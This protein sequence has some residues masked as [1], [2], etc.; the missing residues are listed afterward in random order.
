MDENVRVL[1]D[2]VAHAVR[3]GER[4]LSQLE[5][6]VETV[7]AK[8]QAA[9]AA[10]SDQGDQLIVD[11]SQ[12]TAEFES[13]VRGHLDAQ[14]ERLATF[15]IA[16][17]GR[18]GAGKSTLLSAFG[19]LDGGYVSPGD[20]D[21]T[22]DVTEI[23]WQ[24]C[25][26]WDT[27]GIN[28]WGR[29]Q[30]RAE[31]EETARQAVDI[32]DVVL[33]CF[34][35]QSQQASEFGKVA[36]WVQAYGK[37]TIAVLNVRNLRWRHPAKVSSQS[38]RRSLS[39]AVGEH[40]NNIRTELAKI[41]LG[42]TPV[43]AIQSRR[44]LFGRAKEPFNGPAVSNFNADREQFGAEYLA[45]W[46]NFSVLED[47]IAASIAEGGAELRQTSLREGLRGILDSRAAR[48]DSIR[49]EID[50]R[51]QFTG[52]RIDQFFDT[53]G[54]PEGESRD[55][56]LKADARLV[57]LVEH[58]RGEPFTAASAGTLSR[59][60]DHLLQSHLSSVREATL[61]RADELVD[62]AIDE[63]TQFTDE[64]F[65][66][67][68]SPSDLQT[69]VDKIWAAKTA[70]LQ[71]EIELAVSEVVPDVAETQ[72]DGV[73]FD[74]I[75][76]TSSRAGMA[77]QGAG[78][79]AGAAAGVIVVPSVAAIWNPVGWVGTSTAIGLG[80][81]AQASKF[82]G[83]RLSKRGEDGRAVARAAIQRDS[84]SAVQKTF[85]SIEEDL[86]RQNEVE[87]WSLA[88][89]V[90]VELLKQDVA[91]RRSKTEFAT[92]VDA[93][94]NQSNAITHS[95]ASQDVL[96]RAGRRVLASR[97]VKSGAEADVWL[98]EDW[99]EHNDE[100]SSQ[101]F[102]VDAAH[103]A[104]FAAQR[105]SERDQLREWLAGV[106][107][108]TSQ[109]A[110]ED[111]LHSVTEQL[112]A[113][114]LE[115]GEAIARVTH[116]EH[117]KPSVVILGDYSAGKS[118]LVKRLLVE[119][120]GS[121]PDDLHV[122]GSVATSTASTYELD[123]IRLV[124][125]PGFQS[126]KAAHDQQALEAAA[127]AALVLVVVHVNLL[128]GDMALLELIVKG[129]DETV[130]KD[131]RILYLINRSDELGVDP[132]SSPEDY[133]LLRRRKADE[134]IAA[135][136]SRRIFVDKS[137]V[138]ALAGD[139]FGEVGGQLDVSRGDF[140]SNRDWDGVDP[141]VR[142]LDTFS[143]KQSQ[144]GRTRATV[145]EVCNVLLRRKK[146]LL[147]NVTGFDTESAE[148]G[149]AVQAIANGERDAELLE[150]SM[151]NRLKR[152]L[153][154]HADKARNSIRAA[155]KDDMAKVGELTA[156]W[157]ADPQLISELDRF[158][159]G[160]AQDIDTWFAKHASSI[161]R[162]LK[163][164][165]LAEGAALG[166]EGAFVGVTEGVNA[167]K[168]VAGSA[169]HTAKIAKAI[170]NRDTIY[171]IGKSLGVKFKPWGAVKAGGRVAKAAPILAAIGTAADAHAMYKGHKAGNDREETRRGAI[172]F[173]DDAVQ[174][175]ESELLLGTDNDGPVA[176]LHERS[177]VLAEH[178][179]TLEKQNSDLQALVGAASTQ[180]D[181][182]TKLLEA[183]SELFADERSAR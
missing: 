45:E 151:R 117:P 7:L 72:T 41:D 173:V 149:A 76:G 31:L 30:K 182:M 81:F 134:L 163:S 124:D 136:G 79:A 53:L 57:T 111:W 102:E 32:A 4:E 147:L 135:L 93:L 60:F 5:R 65:Q 6:S 110:V 160:V 122:R 77:L 10:D 174:T 181:Q 68:Y 121:V 62:K 133:L 83:G 66:S 146:E 127:G 78:L 9:V 104:T 123:H 107:Q 15:N 2:A 156:G 73:T 148:I 154:P 87:T 167:A 143:R 91:L 19:E 11:L 118:S 37:P 159:R 141:V 34:D 29:T 56:Y 158:N 44:A 39:R 164:V 126:G 90:L 43:V 165:A 168:I 95:F 86:R 14:R 172:K 71:R 176:A 130:A 105:E 47:L 145:D 35:N 128:I 153:E 80:V 142:T 84:R 26:L 106:W 52:N 51:I 85:E 36:Q 49:Q 180:I 178:R 100:R 46:S 1:Q 157:L 94:Q 42:G 59:H 97:G 17:F 33:L 171:G 18:T 129:T 132:T 24:G 116:N 89:P 183:A 155:G 48:L 162:Q 74:A 92:L 152:I 112:T 23:E 12:F 175:A 150:T 177:G 64:D 54:Y 108:V 144:A 27:P 38:A 20:S 101:Q 119:M 8:F 109:S 98:G 22:T 67:V 131:G 50:P 61:R 40:A 169:H 161:G 13:D 139:P 120:S 55:R 113:N 140:D 70:F 21:W 114:D 166:V 82:V 88:A 179:R 99:F 115:L 125:T 137:E 25:S 75:S 3:S 170:G 69:A 96:D 28:G 63:N 138:H 16:F 58:G 103:R